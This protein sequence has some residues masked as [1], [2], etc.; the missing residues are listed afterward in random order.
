MAKCFQRDVNYDD[1]CNKVYN[2]DPQ[3]VIG[4]LYIECDNMNDDAAITINQS[5]I[6]VYAEVRPYFPR[7]TLSAIESYH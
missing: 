2:R 1:R 6:V 5:E 4:K 7:V 3:C